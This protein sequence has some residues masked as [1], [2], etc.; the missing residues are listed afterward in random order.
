MNP[1]LTLPELLAASSGDDAQRPA[2]LAP[3][4]P[5]L[6]HAGLRQQMAATRAALRHAGIGR[7]DTV[8]VVLQNGPELAAISLAV[9][10]SA[11][12]APLNPAFGADEFRFYLGDLGP[13]ALVIAA[14]DRGRLR[15]I[16]ASLGV[17]CLDVQW[18]ADAPAGACELEGGGASGA[19][20]DD[21]PNP[22]D[23]ALLLH[24][25]GTTSRPKLVPLTHRNL[26]ASTANVVRTL[27]L[28]P[29]DRSLNLMP[30]F[31]IHGFVASLLTSLAAGGGVA[32]CAGYRD[33]EFLPWL[34]ALRP[35][36]YTAAP[37][38]HQA[39]LAELARHPEGIAAK[40][41][42]F[43]RSASA[44]LP[45]PVMRALEAALQAPVIEAYGMTEAAHQ[46]ASNPLPPGERRMGSVGLPAGPSVAIMDEAQRL[47]PR[48]STG[49]IVIRGDNV[50]AGY[51]SPREANA[52]AFATGWFRTGD[53]GSIDDA[54]YVHITGR[55]KELI[56][57]AGE[58]VSPLEVD[59]A[60]LEHSDV[61]Q[62]V[63]FGIEHPT[64]GEDV[65]AAVVLK[66]G[67]STSTAEIRAFLFGRLADYK[68]PS[69]IVV[70]DAIPAGATGKVARATLPAL[71]ASKMRPAFVAPRD[72]AE[73]EM[74]ALFG[75][76][77]GV[78]E[79]GALDNFFTLGGDSLR[80]FQLLTRIREQWQVDIPIVELF[81]EPTLAELAVATA[82]GRR[83][84][85][86]TGQRT[87]RDSLGGHGLIAQTLAALGITHVYGV[88]GQPVYATFA[89]C[90]QAGLRTIGARHQMAAAM[91]AIAHNYFAGRQR[92]VG[93]LS[94][95]APAA[96]AVG[97]VALARTNGWPLLVVAGAA[98]DTAEASGHFMALDTAKLFR[99]VA[100]SVAFAR[101]TEEIAATIRA[102]FDTV[103]EGR[104]GPVV[105]QIPEQALAGFTSPSEERAIAAVPHARTEPDRATVDRAA[106]LL[107]DAKRPLLIVG[108][109]ARWD[110]PYDALRELVE[111][112]ELPFITSP[113]GRGAIPD[114]HPLGMNA[115]R[116][117]AQSRADVAFVLGARL[118][119]TFRH[120]RQLVSR[121][122]IVQVDIHAPELDG[123]RKPTIG[124][125]SDLGSFMRALL[126]APA[127]ASAR[128]V[129]A[130]RDPDW[131]PSLQRARDEIE[132]KRD[133]RARSARLPMSPLRLARELREA[134]PRD[135][136]T[137][138]DGN[139]VMEAMEQAIPVN[140]PASRLT[141]GA[142]GCLGIGVPFALAAKLVHPDRPV[143]AICGDFAFGVSAMELETAVR[144][145]VPIVIVIANNDGNMGAL[146]QRMYMDEG[147]EPI[148]RF[149]PGLRYD[150]I[151][152]MFG[153]QAE[154]VE[155]PEDIRPAIERALSSSRP[156]C[157]NIAV[158]PDAPFPGD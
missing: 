35:S 111:T 7:R 33:G 119:W 110:A 8:A 57:R 126:S 54:G 149:Q 13:A 50:T 34:D 155:R 29:R 79:V 46:I 136:I 107:L 73:R 103:M 59:A 158:D 12:C 27:E 130:R 120:G 3:G 40:R 97:A 9:A 18:T 31:H 71:L 115:I 94:A 95:G 43:A 123:E 154:H 100:K 22:D 138:L 151:M 152:A 135:A 121:A 131:I 85:D 80:A 122:S 146:R 88:P 106:A 142:S 11:R 66:D 19:V 68:I 108:G 83:K 114:R 75:E 65:A 16:A 116:W 140:E 28:G 125:V 20:D 62:A 84:S 30:L 81:K 48:G 70:V 42:R 74:A 93:L 56:N 10:S 87:E 37:A 124:I 52:D 53:L 137:I 129:A 69:Q 24:T 113:L 63:A 98:R 150:Q 17:R 99:P 134:L 4:R 148:M 5:A 25:S 157:I 91:M 117:L 133:A 141:P 58:K 143:I 41:L 92:A 64:M 127:M 23:V 139:L 77:L 89:A 1:A 112:L 67:A 44:P 60:L 55:L 118:N 109:G 102:A 26:C 32:C 15:T 156:A 2:F 39:V 147:A 105:V 128:N 38:I 96:N 45:G 144:H 145:H 90:A 51:A 76:I 132:D 153:G 86:A 101:T 36:W 14:T 82:R 6:S 104:P 61:R 49:E 72:Q 47:L 78:A 21:A